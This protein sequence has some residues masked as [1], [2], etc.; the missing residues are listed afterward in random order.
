MKC[1]YCAYGESKVVD[2]RSTEDGSS[3]RRRR[4]CLKCNRRYTTY[5][6]IETT[7]ILVIKK[8]MS[9]EYFDRNKIVNGLMKACQKRPVSRKQI[10]QIADEVERHISNEMLTEVNTDKIG[11][12]IMKNLKKIDEVS[13]VRFASVYRQ[14]K[15]IN[16]FMKE[17]KNLMDKN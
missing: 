14:F 5:E 12:I 13:Y 16:T 15:D 2:S 9:R 10:E 7:P 17:I 6:K 8:N 11:Q 3:I 1:P 4:E